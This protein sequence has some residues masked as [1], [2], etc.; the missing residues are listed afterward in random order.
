MHA[1]TS[2]RANVF[3]N[4]SQAF[5]QFVTLICRLF[6]A[7][8]NIGRTTEARIDLQADLHIQKAVD[9]IFL[10]HSAFT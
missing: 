3:K 7:E 8:A 9:V 6:I 4:L 2:V 5:S 1:H 10:D